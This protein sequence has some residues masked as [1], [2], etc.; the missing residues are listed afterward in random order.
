M[1]LG[2]PTSRAAPVLCLSSN[3]PFYSCTL[4]LDHVGQ[5]IVVRGRRDASALAWAR[6]GGSPCLPADGGV[7]RS[8]D[9][10]HERLIGIGTAYPG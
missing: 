3:A 2:V 9:R 8:D 4:A 1:R 5:L 10:W 7:S 6:A